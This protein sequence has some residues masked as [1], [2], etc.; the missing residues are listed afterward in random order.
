M[1]TFSRL[2]YVIAA[3]FNALLE[4]A[5]D[6]EKLLRALIREM[7]DAG[8][9]ARRAAADLIAEQQHLQRLD[10]RVAE[11]IDEWSERAERAVASGRDELARAAIKARADLQAR[12]EANAAELEALAARTAQLE[13]DMGTL[14]SKLADARARL[15]AFHARPANASANA[16]AAAAGQERLGRNERR[17]RDALGRFDRLQ[18]Q[19]ERLEARVRSYELGDHMAPAWAAGETPDDPVVEAELEALKAKLAGR[20][21]TEKRTTPAQSEAAQEQA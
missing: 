12:R 17:I 7:E 11:E 1:G 18:N 19:V 16:P 14:K 15:K 4:K 2:R 5:E 20:S 10:R 8:D 6:P 13:T 9:D 3:N 21:G